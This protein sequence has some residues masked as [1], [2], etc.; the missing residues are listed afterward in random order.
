M[1]FVLT[2]W[3]VWIAEGETCFGGAGRVRP[4]WL[5]GGCYSMCRKFSKNGES[6]TRKFNELYFDEF[7]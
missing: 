2:G 4:F 5:N 6:T 1:P 3:L 7:S